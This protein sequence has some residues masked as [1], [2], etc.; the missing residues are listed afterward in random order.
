M[1]TSRRNT[2]SLTDLVVM[3]QE[4]VYRKPVILRNLPRHYEAAGGVHLDHLP[5]PPG[6][7]VFLPPR[8]R[9]LTTRP[10]S[11]P[12]PSCPVLRN[13][14]SGRPRLPVVTCCCASHLE[15]LLEKP[16]LFLAAKR[17]W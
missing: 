10:S 5:S 6:H 9:H 14:G 13:G 2:K 4:M 8:P 17:R 7:M 1:S 11:P 16:T 12:S 3:H 15:K